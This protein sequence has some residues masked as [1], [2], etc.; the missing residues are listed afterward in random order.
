MNGAAD[1]IWEKVNRIAEQ[2][3]ALRGVHDQGLENL[4]KQLEAERKERV[5][6]GKEI[7]SSVEKIRNQ[8]LIGMIVVMALTLVIDKVLK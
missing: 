6:M 4:G 7:I 3:C 1:A 2:G 8:I 5:E